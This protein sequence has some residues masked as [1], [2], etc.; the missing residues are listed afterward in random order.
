MQN[1]LVQIIVTEA[2]EHL[3]RGLVQ[4]AIAFLGAAGAVQQTDLGVFR[5]N[6][7]AS[8]PEERLH[9]VK[10]A[11]QDAGPEVASR[12]HPLEDV[13]RR[14]LAS[15]G[16]GGKAGEVR[17]FVEAGAAGAVR[18]DDRERPDD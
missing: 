1:Y 12:A 5:R 8:S 2:H 9:V 16:A 4:M 6:G 15:G 17:V 18:E 3:V 14:T 10:L 7:R 13:L 11:V